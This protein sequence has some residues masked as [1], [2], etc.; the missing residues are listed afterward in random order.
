MLVRQSGGKVPSVA[1][2]PGLKRPWFMDDGWIDLGNDIV[3]KSN[4]TLGTS[5]SH[6]ALRTEYCL[7]VSVCW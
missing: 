3:N 4:G 1:G 7:F 6:L 5:I 2:S